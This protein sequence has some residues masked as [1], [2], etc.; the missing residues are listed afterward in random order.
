MLMCVR[1]KVI[2]PPQTNS[3]I[4]DNRA[5]V[6]MNTHKFE[7]KYRSTTTL[8]QVHTS[9]MD[10]GMCGSM[11][12]LRVNVYINVFFNIRGAQLLCK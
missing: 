5:F 11:H 12:S 7:V 4:D 2:T 8:K 1:V 6:Q 3:S 10:V 9:T